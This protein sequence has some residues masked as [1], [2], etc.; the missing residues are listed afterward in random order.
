MKQSPSMYAPREVK[1]EYSK[2]ARPG[3]VAKTKIQPVINT[4]S[5]RE[6]GLSYKT[7]PSLSTTGGST[8]KKA[9]QMYSGDRL[10]GISI[11]HKSCLQP[12]FSNDEAKEFAS[13]R[14]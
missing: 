5:I 13:M 7:I 4:I 6:D 10:I 9:E 12:V 14:R 8:A 1:Q 3:S 11:C 2:F